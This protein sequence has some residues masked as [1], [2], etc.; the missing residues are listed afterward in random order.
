M[1]ADKSMLRRISDVRAPRNETPYFSLYVRD[2]FSIDCTW[3]L[4]QGS[5]SKMAEMKLFSSLNV[6]ISH[7]ENSL[8]SLLS[9]LGM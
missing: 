2:Y 6:V 8:L 7:T 1:K 9:G 5:V 3:S 4:N